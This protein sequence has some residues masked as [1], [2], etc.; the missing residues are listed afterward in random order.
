MKGDPIAIEFIKGVGNERPMEAIR[1]LDFN[2]P[3]GTVAIL[4]MVP[5]GGTN[6]AYD[7]DGDGN[8][9]TI[10]TPSASLTGSAAT[11]L[12]APT[13]TIDGTSQHTNVLVTITAQDDELGTNAVYYSLNGSYYQ[14]Y[15][16]PILV[17]PAQTSI[18]SAFA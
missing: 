7:S 11:D 17:S 6:L 14:R 3:A 13:V 1:Y 16:G 8:V 9:D 10:V 5:D 4:R 2:L 12:S 15:A 18:V